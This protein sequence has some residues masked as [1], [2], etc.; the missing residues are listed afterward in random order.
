MVVETRRFDD[1]QLKT[2]AVKALFREPQAWHE[3]YKHIRKLD[4]FVKFKPITMAIWPR[5]KFSWQWVVRSDSKNSP[6]QPLDKAR[7]MQDTEIDE[8]KQKIIPSICSKY[9]I[10]CQSA[11]VYT[12]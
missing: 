9:Q 7:Q 10:P 6:F 8:I 1:W 4:V 2:V 5:D 3:L 11:F 12:Q